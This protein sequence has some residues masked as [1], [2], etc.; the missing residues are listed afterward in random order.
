MEWSKYFNKDILIIDTKSYLSELQL[1]QKKNYFEILKRKEGQFE[2]ELKDLEE[3]VSKKFISE[4]YTNLNS[5]ILLE[6]QKDMIMKLNR[7]CLKLDNIKYDFIIKTLE[8]LYNI[9]N[10][11]KKRIG[12]KDIKFLE[13]NGIQRCSYKFCKFK[14]NCSYNYNN[15]KNICYQDHYV[16]NMVVCDLKQIINYLKKN[17]DN[18]KLSDLSKSINTISYVINRMHKELNARCLYISDDNEI[19]KEHVSKKK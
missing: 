12:Q 18:K 2:K 7:Y 3:Y 13:K 11:L 5:L 17:K 19:E 14:E 15:K 1:S 4:N 6:K 9:S 8:Y 10:I 16:H